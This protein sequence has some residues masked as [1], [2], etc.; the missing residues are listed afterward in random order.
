LKKK[1][2]VYLDTSF[3]SALHYD[4]SNFDCIYRQRKTSEWWKSEANHFELISSRI[5]ESEL[6]KGHYLNQE[7]AIAASRRLKYLPITREVAHVAQAY[8]KA[9]LVPENKRNDA[10]QLAFS[11]VYRIDYLMS[12][13]YAH[14][15]NPEVQKA[16]GRLN[17]SRKW[18]S[19]LLVS[20]ETIPQIRFGQ[21]VGKK[22]KR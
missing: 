9:F 15:A 22:G 2:A 20:P 7:A 12:W 14:L 18:H 6:R 17:E 4:G 8:L 5:T 13:N 1:P 10:L 16:M 19:P 3:V 11:V 21:D